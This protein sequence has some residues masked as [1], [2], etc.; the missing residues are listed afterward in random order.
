MGAGLPVAPSAAARTLPAARGTRQSRRQRQG[1]GGT[2]RWAR[3]PL[4]RCPGPGEAGAQA[5]GAGV[6]TGA[7]SLW[8][9]A[10]QE[11][12]LGTGRGSESPLG[13]RGAGACTS[14]PSR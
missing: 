7:G 12:P 1:V 2:R 8:A 9:P 5:E 10:L 13:P 6:G 14:L 11:A 4:T 3:R